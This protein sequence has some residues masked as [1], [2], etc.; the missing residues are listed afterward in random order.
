MTNLQF[1]DLVQR[2]MARRR[3][4]IALLLGTLACS[5]GPPFELP[6]D[7]KAV[8]VSLD[9]V[10]GYGPERKNLAPYLSIL[11]DGTVLAPSRYGSTKDH[12]STIPEAKLQELL[13]F[14]IGENRFF[15]YDA[16]EVQERI[17]SYS[18]VDAGTTVIR[19]AI[20]ARTLEV[21]QYALY[22]MTRKHPEVEDLQRL[23]AIATRLNNFRE[24]A[25]IGGEQEAREV[26][27]VVNEHLRKEHPR[28]SPFSLENMRLVHELHDGSRSAVFTLRQS[29]RRTT[30]RIVL[31]REG[32][33]V[34][35][36]EVRKSR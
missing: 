1:L 14:I 30:V 6:D 8:V 3:L 11:R 35:S 27:R 31:P 19:V 7:P 25:V 23:K 28:A 10:G 33:P 36:V 2:V 17:G 9:Y 4:A 12:V 16:K 15:D 26:L 20:R 5:K 32:P 34:V 18:I 29:N 22:N 13:G 21:R 24:V